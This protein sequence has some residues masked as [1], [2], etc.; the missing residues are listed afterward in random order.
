[1]IDPTIVK[2]VARLA[3]L[4]LD[5]EA[6]ERVSGELTRILEH[7]ARLEE[8][9]VTEVPPLMHGTGGTDVFR[10]DVQGPVLPVRD[11]LGNAPAQSQGCF[12]VPR[13]IGDG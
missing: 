12:S 9:D 1:M 3:R 5:D 13:I 8:L 11:A 4:E 10:D 6:V 7:V 2:K